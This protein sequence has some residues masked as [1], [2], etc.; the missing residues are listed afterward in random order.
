MMGYT[1][2]TLL[3]L[4]P[5]SCLLQSEAAAA[6]VEERIAGRLERVRVRDLGL[7]LL[8]GRWE[9]VW[10]VSVCVRLSEMSLGQSDA[11]HRVK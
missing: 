11:I 5:C 2:R 7:Q 1:V 6:T 9:G 8:G 10:M 4:R 3:C